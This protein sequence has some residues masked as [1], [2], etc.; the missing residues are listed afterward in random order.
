[1][2]RTEWTVAV[3]VSL[4]VAS[5][6]EAQ[7]LAGPLAATDATTTVVPHVAK[8]VKRPA[9]HS[10]TAAS[11]RTAAPAAARLPTDPVVPISNPAGT[12]ATSPT[13]PVSFGMKWN[14]SNDNASQTRIENLNGQ[15]TGTGAEV[16]MKLHF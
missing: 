12:S 10:K 8:P 16:G 15:A 7:G 2:R 1:M 4:S 9:R 3:L 6:A 5:T 14:G 13:N 11:K